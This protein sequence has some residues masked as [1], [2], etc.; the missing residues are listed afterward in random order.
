[1][2]QFDVKALE[3][4][5]GPP[6]V[7]APLHDDVHLLISVLAHVSADDPAPVWFMFFRLHII[8]IFGIFI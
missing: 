2:A 5:L 8:C 3:A 6:A 7:V 4:L 1:M